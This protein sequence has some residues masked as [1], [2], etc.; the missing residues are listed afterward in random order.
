MG[1]Y[2]CGFQTLF[3]FLLLGE[4]LIPRGLLGYLPRNK[5]IVPPLSVGCFV[6]RFVELLKCSFNPLNPELNPI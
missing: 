2:S 1:L 6:K 5:A 3:S 4:P